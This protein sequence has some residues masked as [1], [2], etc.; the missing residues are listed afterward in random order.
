M[1]VKLEDSAVQNGRARERLRDRRRHGGLRAE[2]DVRRVHE[3][4]QTEAESREQRRNVQVVQDR[5]R[6]ECGARAHEHVP[7]AT[8]LYR[9]SSSKLECS[10]HSTLQ[11]RKPYRID[12]LLYIIYL[13]EMRFYSVTQIV[14]YIFKS[15]VYMQS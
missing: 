2:H 3:R 7:M 11:Y 14:L 9:S 1:R 4:L 10:L 15:Q 13:I 6:V 8:E 12:I 5:D